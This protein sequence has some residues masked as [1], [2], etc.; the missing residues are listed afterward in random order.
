[1][2]DPYRWIDESGSALREDT[3]RDKFYIPFSKGTNVCM[4]IQ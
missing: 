2:F 4:G 3:L 1:M